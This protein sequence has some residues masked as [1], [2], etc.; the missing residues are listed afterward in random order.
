[1]IKSSF[2][3]LILGVCLG[4]S[5]SF[6][7]TAAPTLPSPSPEA[8]SQTTVPPAGQWVYTSQY[9]WLWLPYQQDYT[10]VDADSQVSYA[11]ALRDR[12][13]GAPFVSCWLEQHAVLD[14]AAPCWARVSP[15]LAS[16][17]RGLD[18]GG[19]DGLTGTGR[20]RVLWSRRDDHPEG[21][22]HHCI[23]RPF[24]NRSRSPSMMTVPAPSQ[25]WPDNQIKTGRLGVGLAPGTS[26]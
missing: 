14:R 10:Y 16:D 4:S 25:S 6:A 7:D 15:S 2:P 19:C 23:A 17:G 12:A 8:T 1:M 3:S 21:G 5:P 11:S 24:R 18:G 13:S 26:S 22:R 9:G 20:L